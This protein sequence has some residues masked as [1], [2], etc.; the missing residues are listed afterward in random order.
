[1]G[2]RVS[3]HDR[4]A[5]PGLLVQ[6]GFDLAQLDTMAADLHLV[7]APADDVERSVGAPPGEIARAIHPRTRLGSE[8][9]G[10]ETL[11]GQPRA[12]QIAA[13]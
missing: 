12:P 4:L 5:D 7:V 1:M 3:H 9:I 13:S 2:V 11:R 8:W 10:D 6:H